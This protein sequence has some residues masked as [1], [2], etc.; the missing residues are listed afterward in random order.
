M[1]PLCRT[2]GYLDSLNVYYFKHGALS[3]TCSSPV[4][5]S[6]RQECEG[7]REQGKGREGGREEVRREEREGG[8]KEGGRETEGDRGER[9]DGRE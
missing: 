2:P 4:E 9:D 5:A 1:F 8:R 3:S 6:K 7:G